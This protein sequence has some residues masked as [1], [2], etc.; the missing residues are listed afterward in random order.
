MTHYEASSK[1][2]CSNC[3]RCELICKEDGKCFK[4]EDIP[5]NY[6]LKINFIGNS[7]IEFP[8]DS[9]QELKSAESD[10]LYN[11]LFFITIQGMIINRN[12]ITFTE[13]INSAKIFV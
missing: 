1:G 4:E 3:E 6:I 7:Y 13:V 8:F 11:G 2:K 9:L 10:I 12:N 5:Y